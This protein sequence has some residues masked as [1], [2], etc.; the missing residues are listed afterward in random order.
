MNQT[1]DTVRARFG[2]II[3]SSNRM[4][5]PHA[6]RYSP[7]GV[8]PHTARLRMTGPYFMALD[9]LLPKVAEAAAMLADAKCDP[10]VFHCTANSMADGVDGEKRIVRAIEE[11]TG[12]AATTTASATMAAFRALGAQRLVLVSPYERAT[13]EHELH[14]M[15]EVGIEVV[16]ERNL[17]LSGS[18]AYCGMAPADWV[19]T[20]TAMRNDRA[21][22]YFVSCAN[23][24]AIEVIEEL[25]S[26]LGRPVVTSNQVVIW[27]ALRL[28]GIDEPVAG[29]G[30]LAQAGATALA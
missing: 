16:G 14:F 2:M 28:A 11:A 9:A 18:D 30:R 20:M 7:A 22:A 25:E 29:L 12:G 17:G 15:D 3:P 24:R 6:C 19:E 8:V 4:A 26:R 27:Q 5:E 10:V 13:H 1:S 21:D 23:I